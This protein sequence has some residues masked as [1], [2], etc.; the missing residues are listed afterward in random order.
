MIRLRWEKKGQGKGRGRAGEGRG[1][2]GGL[3]RGHTGILADILDNGAAQLGVDLGK[4]V[5][6][7]LTRRASRLRV[8]Q[9]TNIADSNTSKAHARDS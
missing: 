1:R 2:R 3:H 4:R 5:L 9:H 6:V 7:H 8:S